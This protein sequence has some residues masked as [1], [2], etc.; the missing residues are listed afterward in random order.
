MFI[1]KLKINLPAHQSAFLWGARKV[2]KSTWLKQNFP[3]CMFI[4][5]LD[6]KEI[7]II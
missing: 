5:L 3:D 2:G 1:R 6:F 7:D 4:D